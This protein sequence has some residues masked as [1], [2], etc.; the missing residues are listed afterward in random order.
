[1]RVSISI[2]TQWFYALQL[3]L[4]CVICA[5][6][7]S[8]SHWTNLQISPDTLC[9]MT[10]RDFA[11]K[12]YEHFNNPLTTNASQK[13]YF[14]SPI[15]MLDH[16]SVDV[17]FNNVTNQAKLRF[18]VEMWNDQLQSE[19]ANYLPQIVGHEIKLYQVQVISFDKVLLAATKPS[20]IYSW[21]ANW[22]P[23]QLEKSVWFT[24][25]CLQQKDCNELQKNIHKDPKNFENLKILFSLSSQSTN[26]KE[27]VIN[28]KDILFGQMVS[29]LLQKFSSSPELFLTI[30]D[31]NQ[32]LWEITS[33]VIVETLNDSDVVSPYSESQ[34]FNMMNDVLVSS[35]TTIFKQNDIL[36]KY[37]FWNDDDYRPDKTS[38]RLNE[39]Y[40][41]L[42]TVNREK[43]LDSFRNS[44]VDLSGESLK[45][46]NIKLVRVMRDHVEWNGQKFIP[47]PL[48]L[49]KINL[50]NL[51][52]AHK[53]QDRRV[54]VSYSIAALSIP[55]RFTQFGNV[56]N[57]DKWAELKKELKG[58]IYN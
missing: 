34:I 41:K 47:K 24:L 22:H 36:W 49:C 15:T 46:E 52:D 8:N 44:V 38:K 56:T 45:N 20:T 14:Y 9:S 7:N 13:R 18:S 19:V 43:M 16:K 37:V 51:R 21:S 35:R 54:K 40:K 12:I 31:V 26:S 6:D 28:F 17:E 1:M 27:I 42:D 29:K 30:E 33:N 3:L 11:I 4:V 57:P 48:L 25:T 53:V 10:Y 5:I 39:I 50:G 55:I 32:L 23:Y 58:T 2:V